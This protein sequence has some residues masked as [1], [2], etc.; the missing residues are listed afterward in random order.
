MK[1]FNNPKELTEYLK[2]EAKEGE[3]VMLDEAPDFTHTKRKQ[4]FRK[5]DGGRT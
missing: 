2:N 5:S 3:V 1:T 4:T